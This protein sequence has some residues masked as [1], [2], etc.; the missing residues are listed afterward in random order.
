MGSIL[1]VR[2]FLCYS[3]IFYGNVRSRVSLWGSFVIVGFMSRVVVSV[4]EIFVLVMDLI[5][6]I[7]SI[8]CFRGFL[9]YDKKYDF[10]Y[11][12]FFW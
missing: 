3:V 11:F 7:V 5:G 12:F 1:I 6:R 4:S 2:W 9:L 10:Y 8:L